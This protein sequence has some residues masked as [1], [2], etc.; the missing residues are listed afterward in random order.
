MANE[1]PSRSI[2]RASANRITPRTDTGN[3]P[4]NCVPEDEQEQKHSHAGVQPALGDDELG[5]L[6]FET[7][8]IPTPLICRRKRRRV[9]FDRL[10]TRGRGFGWLVVAEGRF[11]RQ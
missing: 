5:L 9:A 4:V 3:V 6:T 7:W 8:V 1:L 2:H 10:R 11:Y